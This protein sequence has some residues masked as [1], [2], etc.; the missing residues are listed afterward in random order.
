MDNNIITPLQVP[1]LSLT[2]VGYGQQLNDLVDNINNNFQRIIESDFLRGPAGESF[3][4]TVVP[5]TADSDNNG[6]EYADDIFAA[7]IEGLD[8]NVYEGLDASS[9]YGKSDNPNNISLI[10]KIIDDKNELISSLPFVYIDPRFSDLN[11]PNI[12]FENIEDCSCIVQVVDGKFKAIKTFPTLYYDGNLEQFCW[13][14]NGVNTG[15]IARGPKGDTGNN[16]HIYIMEVK[17]VTDVSNKFIV[18]P[19]I[20]SDDFSLSHINNGDF[21]FI[22]KKNAKNDYEYFI[23]ILS[24][25]NGIVYATISDNSIYNQFTGINFTDY[26]KHIDID[27]DLYPKGLFIPINDES[28]HVIC[29]NAL[30]NINNNGN[31]DKLNMNI[32]PISNFS[33][34]SSEKIEVVRNIEIDIIYHDT[35]EDIVENHLLTFNDRITN[36]STLENIVGENNVKRLLTVVTGQELADINSYTNINIYYF[37]TA[38]GLVHLFSSRLN[39]YDNDSL[40][41]IDNSHNTPQYSDTHFE[42]KY[43]SNKTYL[44]DNTGTDIKNTSLNIGYESINFGVHDV[45]SNESRDTSLNIKGNI[46]ATSNIKSNDIH[47]NELKTENIKSLGSKLIIEDPNIKTPYIEGDLK[48]NSQIIIGDNAGISLSSDGINGEVI[49]ILGSEVNIGNKLRNDGNLNITIPSNIT[50]NVNINCGNTQLYISPSKMDNYSWGN[51]TSYNTNSYKSM[52]SN[53]NNISGKSSTSNSWRRHLDEISKT[54]TLTYEFNECYKNEILFKPIIV[55]FK[56]QGRDY[57]G[58]DY[59]PV[60]TYS[61]SNLSL[62][63]YVDGVL[64]TIT[65]QN[66][67]FKAIKKS[68]SDF[69]RSSSGTTYTDYVSINLPKLQTSTSSYISKVVIKFKVSMDGDNGN[70][71]YTTVGDIHILNLMTGYSYNNASSNSISLGA[72]QSSIS[73]GY[74]FI[75]EIITHNTTSIKTVICSDGIMIGQSKDAHG[76]IYWD[77]NNSKLVFKE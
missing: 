63:Y 48:T 76:R 60:F 27:T 41:V 17:D 67:N 13:K 59:A 50:N 32:L 47:T 61:I 51:T 31:D 64:K 19:L 4:L 68:K 69:A 1:N 77:A 73:T 16:G 5:V 35:H 65:G 28:V 20:T 3:G 75:K 6:T 22:A 66:S 9:V 49:N 36:V 7:V 40:F 44:K 30:S 15:L 52:N 72:Q 12:D 54:F 24:V 74:D 57:K 38:N 21:A 53:S 70:G 39:I 62:E 42:I 46:I 8:E 25:S 26:L 58:T 2:D 55:G 11:N 45:N 18:D 71:D 14:L 33:V 37:T 23:G 43:K 10:Y 29:A 56:Y 34:L